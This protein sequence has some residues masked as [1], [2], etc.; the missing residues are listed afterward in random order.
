MNIHSFLNES[1]CVCVPG[2]LRCRLTR[3]AGTCFCLRGGR[4]GPWS[5]VRPL[6]ELQPRSTSLFPATEGWTTSTFSTR[7]TEAPPCS[8]CGTSACWST[9]AGKQEVD[10]WKWL[11]LRWTF[12]CFSEQSTDAF[13]LNRL[14]L[15]FWG[16]C[17]NLT[18]YSFV[19][20]SSLTLF[21]MQNSFLS[22]LYVEMCCFS[23]WN[24]YNWLSFGFGL[25]K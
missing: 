1:L 12:D 3:S 23:F 24:Q 25:T 9:T 8:S 18:T 5:G 15:L 14:W 21:F 20:D 10:N 22:L 11:I 7:R 2:S 13:V 4:C 19:L 17:N 16:S 6:M